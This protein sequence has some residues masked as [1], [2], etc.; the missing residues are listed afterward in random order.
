MSVD[1]TL[2]LP[3]GVSPDQGGTPYRYKPKVLMVEFGDV[4]AGIRFLT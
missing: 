3:A 4:K 2:T 1:Y